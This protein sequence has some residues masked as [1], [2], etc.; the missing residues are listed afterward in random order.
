[1]TTDR[2]RLLTIG[3]GASDRSELGRRLSDA[4][5][6]ALVDVRRFPGSR[7]NPDVGTDAMQEWV[8]ELG[9]QYIWDERLGGR[10]SLSKDAPD[11]DA[12]WRVEQFRAYAAHTRTA[13]FI[14]AMQDLVERS[15]NQLTAVM[16]SENVWW[17]CHRRLIADVAVVV[18]DLSVWH[19][20]P[21]G[22]L[23]RHD[24]SP[25]AAVT[26]EHHVEWPNADD[27]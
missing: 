6:E 18:H 26:S 15:S 27:G 22:R 1:M 25:T 9:I 14:A 13:P 23:R 16:C 10:R 21:D 3:H 4:G 12:W 17:R 24:V 11:T 19:V 5:I 2:N 20:M 7:H 8:P